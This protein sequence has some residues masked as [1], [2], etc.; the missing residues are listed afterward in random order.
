MNTT[1]STPSNRYR[2][3]LQIW[4]ELSLTRKS[5]EDGKYMRVFRVDDLLK[6]EG[7]EH[8]SQSSVIHSAPTA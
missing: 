1:V 3:L 7:E 8:D 5:S 6:L 2:M 4:K